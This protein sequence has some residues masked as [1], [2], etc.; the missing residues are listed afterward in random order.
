MVHTVNMD[1]FWFSTFPFANTEPI[2][3]VLKKM[4]WMFVSYLKRNKTI[5]QKSK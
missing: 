4:S 5:L 2:I 3:L 1:A